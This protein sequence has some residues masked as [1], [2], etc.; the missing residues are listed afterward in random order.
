MSH[1]RE[2]IQKTETYQGLDPFQREMT[3]SKTNRLHIE[4]GVTVALNSGLEYFEKTNPQYSERNKNII[5]EIYLSN[6]KKSA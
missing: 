5:R 4:H 2:K 1:F 3:M 6:Q